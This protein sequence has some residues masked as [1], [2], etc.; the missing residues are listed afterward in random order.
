MESYF[1]FLKELILLKWPHY[2][3]QSTNLKFNPYENT[4]NIFHKTGINNPKIY[5]ELQK[6]LNCQNN[7]EKKEQNWKYQVL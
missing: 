3:K 6:T 7:L 2:S 5:M 4:H 1:V